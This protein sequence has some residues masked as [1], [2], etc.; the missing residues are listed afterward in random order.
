LPEKYKLFI[1]G[2]WQLDRLE[3]R[4][5]LEY[6]TEPSLIPTFP[7]DILYVLTLPTLPKHDDSLAMAYY[8]T[9]SPPLLSDK[10]RQGFFETLCRSSVTE[11]FYFTRQH[12]EEYHRR[13]LE[14]LIAYVHTP[15]VGGARG[16]RARE[17]V[18]LPLDDEEERWFEDY[19]LHDAAK[20]LPGAKDTVLMRRFA[21]G[22]L[23]DLPADLEWLGGKK[24]DGINWDDLRRSLGPVPTSEGS[25]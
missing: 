22:K 7:D 1:D 17:L 12:G 9:V 19:L 3:L 25:S 13:Y 24:V 16:S 2:L 20:T 6:L 23:R 4:R 10:A 18:N 21:T 15:I 14:Q 11:A 8:L 5:A